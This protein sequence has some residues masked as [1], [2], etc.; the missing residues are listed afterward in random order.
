MFL[1]NSEKF[2]GAHICG[3]STNPISE[4]IIPEEIINFI[5]LN[6]IFASSNA[7][8]NVFFSSLFNTSLLP[9][10]AVSFTPTFLVA[11]PNI[12]AFSLTIYTLEFVVPQSIIAKYILYHP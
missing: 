11:F 5:S 3:I 7:V 8:K 9:L 1:A 4:V 2:A 10:I 12:S 6:F